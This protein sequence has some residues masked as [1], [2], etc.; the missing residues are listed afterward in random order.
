MKSAQP[1]SLQG[2]AYPCHA[3]TSWRR[4]FIWARSRSSGNRHSLGM[5]IYLRSNSP[6][7]GRQLIFSITIRVLAGQCLQ[8]DNTTRRRIWVR[9]LVKTRLRVFA[10]R[11]RCGNRDY[12][13]LGR[14][15]WSWSRR[16]W[17]ARKRCLNG[18]CR[19]FWR[20]WDSS[21]PW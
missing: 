5:S 19:C 14:K 13:N 8:V 6:D 18:Y 20:T 12:R 9:W 7:W 2:R 11:G 16:S 4:A 1:L 3:S 10:Q 17:L 21:S 15:F